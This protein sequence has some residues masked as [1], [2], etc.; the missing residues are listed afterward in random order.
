[1]ER[2][3][4]K[5]LMQ[6]DLVSVVRQYYIERDAQA[7]PTVCAP[8]IV[9]RMYRVPQ[10]LGIRITL[11]HFHCGRHGLCRNVSASVG[12][13]SGMNVLSIRPQRHR[14]LA[15]EETSRRS[16]NLFRHSHPSESW[17]C[18][19]LHFEDWH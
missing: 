14:N 11:G 4:T 8:T 10:Q 2:Y 6:N 19:L 15:P 1:M 18:R 16:F 7:N 5:P 9:H 13:E 17:F 12:S 3:L